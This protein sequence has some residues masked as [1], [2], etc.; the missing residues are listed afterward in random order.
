MKS[1][2][3]DTSEHGKTLDLIMS[4]VYENRLVNGDIRSTLYSIQSKQEQYQEKVLRRMEAQR[5]E[6]ARQSKIQESMQRYVQMIMILVAVFGALI[7]H[8]LKM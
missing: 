2:N 8:N 3:E 6:L 5:K 4:N 1:D 7:L